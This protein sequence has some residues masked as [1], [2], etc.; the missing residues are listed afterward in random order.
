MKNQELARLFYREVLKT[1]QNETLDIN[2]KVDALYRQLNLLFVEATREE[3]L[4]FTTLFA[5]IAFA[6]HKFNLNKQL[7]FYIHE[8]RRIAR[9]LSRSKV[10]K[11][12]DLDLSYQLGLKVLTL[13]IS[14]VFKTGIPGDL[15]EQLP[16]D[17][18]YKVVPREIKEFKAFARVV[19]LEDLENKDQFLIRDEE[20]PSEE[21]FLQY[22]I[23]DRNENFN[24]SIKAIRK[25]FKFPVILNLIDVEIDKDGIYRPRA[26]VIEPDYLIDV[27]AIAECFKDGT[28]VSWVHLLKKY[29]PVNANKYLMI[30]NIANFF[31][32]ELMTNPEVTFKETFPK[33]FRLNPL[34]FTIFEN[35]EVRDIMQS[36]QKHFLNLK[37]MVAQDF[38]E[39]DIN[40]D[41]CFLEPSFYAERY[42]IQGRL[43]VF[44]KNPDND[45][46]S[47]IVELKSGKAYKPNRWGI[48]QNHYIQTLLYDLM[49][50]SVFEN[51]LNPTN[52][53]LY[54]GVDER[55]LRFAPVTKSNQFEAIQV[56][57]QLV[58]IE[59]SLIQL[60]QQQ[61]G[62]LNLF[63]KMN[64]ARMPQIQGFLKRDLEMFYKV[65]M[66]MNDLEKEYF[67]SYSGFIAREHQLAKTGVQGIENVNGLASLWL[68]DPK[69]KQQNFDIISFLEIH[70]I[71]AKEE[72]PL[73]IFHKTEQTSQLANF[74]NG[75]IAVLYP[76]D[77]QAK[78]VLSNQIFKCTI[79]EIN[80]TEVI[81]RLRSRQ[82]NESIFHQYQHW[83]LEHD[84]FDS[85]F[86]SMYRSLFKFIQFPEEKKDL[87]L[88]TT[89]PRKAE[90]KEIKAPSQLTDEQGEIFAKAIN[91]PDY[92]LL[93]GPPGTG[94]TSVMLRQLVSYILN[95]TD[96]NILLLAYTN[97]AVDEICESVESI[98]DYITQ[99]Y[100]RIGS[101]YSTADR[102][103]KQLLQNK[104]ENVSNRQELK[105]VIESH[106]I[107][108]S[109]VASIASK[110]ELLQ[111]KK[112][113]RV[114]IDEAS[115]ILEPILVGLLP[116]FERFILIGDHKQLPAVVVQNQ[117]ESATTAKELQDIG[118]YNLRD[119]LFERLFKRCESNGWDWAF[120]RLSHQGRM[121]QHIM[122]FP[123]D[124]FYQGFLDILPPH[125]PTSH[126]QI[127]TLEYQLPLEPTELETKLCQ[128]RMHF[129]PTLTDEDSLTSKTNLHEAESIATLVESFHRIFEIN[130][131]KIN[132]NSIGIITPY[133]AQIAQIREILQA[134]NIDTDQLTIDTVERYQGGAREVILI[135]LCVNK[136]SQ[137]ESL[138]STS[139]DGVDRKLNVALTRARQHLVLVG[140]TSILQQN[141]IYKELIEFCS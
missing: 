116:Q 43:D 75:D 5:R 89:A 40:P 109:T 42:G 23:A 125:F 3:K 41:H 77:E 128:Q 64:P 19:A 48:S 47:A 81:I 17:G 139:G 9:Q 1:H 90:P 105:D 37:R 135:S 25:V 103:K 29:L 106:R 61:K 126:Q 79:I 2:A 28:V 99:E 98:D 4:Q 84:L 132:A 108:V 11:D 45:K 131:K 78:G 96:E 74:R 32:D 104:I 55:Q 46:D 100:I 30:G 18:F 124:F 63:D 44:Y 86:N 107:F 113:D 73:I 127:E 20:N 85:G 6:G 70:E 115:Q 94:K 102:F 83:N 120:A 134:R 38:M 14:S 49:I 69:E 65:Y 130:N 87:L 12:L 59:Q 21:V 10:N 80:K 140:N 136:K 33:V 71:K 92:F 39:N 82:F 57:N 137:L 119:S 121:H 66:G 35:R 60:N 24:S 95:E 22:N 8:F 52:F 7:Q 62:S 72:S 111:L 31:L 54:S 122:D 67:I 16:P 50:K 110:H 26:F 101:N 91:A 36:S 112:F 34:A 97:R 15:A 51:R 27:S 114:I 58:A 88:T 56:R 68:N 133:R 13:S 138:V 53:I 129:I 117:E 123:N 93:W 76:L 141:E 118:L